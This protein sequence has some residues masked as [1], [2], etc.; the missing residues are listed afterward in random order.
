[1]GLSTYFHGEIRDVGM[2]EFTEC[3]S[4][5]TGHYYFLQ[6]KAVVSGL[7]ECDLSLEEYKKSRKVFTTKTLQKESTRYLANLKKQ[8]ANLKKVWKSIG[9]R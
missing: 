4:A 7:Y 1:M 8:E 5:L 6:D 2:G 3:L 9:D